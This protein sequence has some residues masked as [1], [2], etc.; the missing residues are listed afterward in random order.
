MTMNGECSVADVA[1]FGPEPC[2]FPVRNDGPPAGHELQIRIDERRQIGRELHDGTAQLLVA[3][4]LSL[5]ILREQLEASEA[6]DLMGDVDDTIAALHRE[7]RSVAILS[8]GSIELPTSLGEALAEM[9][10]GFGRLTGTEVSLDLSHLDT[11]LPAEVEVAF[12]R[13]AQ[14]ALANARRHGQADRV[15]IRVRRVAGTMRMSVRDNGAGF[16]DGATGGVGLAS[17]HERLRALGGKVAIRRLSDGTQ[18]NLSV[19]LRGAGRALGETPM[20]SGRSPD[21]PWR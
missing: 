20:A 15:A 18:L 19:P 3:L 7:I 16:P 8:P 9:A 4:Q 12:F 2:P 11:Q 5:A 14:E 1:A 6:Q 13:I 10:N 17:I 21:E